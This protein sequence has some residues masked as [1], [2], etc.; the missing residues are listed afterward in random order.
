MKQIKVCTHGVRVSYKERRNDMETERI[1]YTKIV[2]CFVECESHIH[3]H[4]F[5]L[6]GAFKNSNYKVMIFFAA[7]VK[8]A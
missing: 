1:I 2:D 6:Y 8:F 3:E 7:V 4:N 5:Q